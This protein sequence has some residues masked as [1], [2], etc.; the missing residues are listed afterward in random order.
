[1]SDSFL[2]K[3]LAENL[4]PFM[5]HRVTS[6]L[7]WSAEEKADGEALHAACSYLVTPDTPGAVKVFHAERYGGGG[8]QRNGGGARCG[9]DGRYQVK[10]IGANPLVGQG[11]DWYH[12]NGELRAEQ[13]IYEALWSEMLAQTLPYGAARTHAILLTDSYTHGD[14]TRTK[15]RSRRALL[16]REPLVR[17]AH[18]ERTPYFR[19]KAEYAGQLMHDVQRVKSVLRRL[20]DYLPVP[21][22]GFSEQAARDPRRRCLEG[23]YELTKRLARQMAFCRTRFLMLT[24][25]S[26]NITMDGRVLDFNGLTCLFP[27]DHRYDFEYQL[28]FAQLM[29]EPAIIQNSLSELCFYLGKYLF[30]RPFIAIAQQQVKTYFWHFFQQAC[31]RGYLTLLGI[32]IDLLSPAETPKPLERLANSFLQLLIHRCRKLY[33]SAEM[34][35][36]ESPLE[37]LV[38]TLIRCSQGH[39]VPTHDDF[40]RDARFMGTLR[41]FSQVNHWLVE[42]C[43]AQGIDAT[44]IQ[45][46][47]AQQARLRLRPRPQCGKIQMLNEIT[48]LVEANGDDDQRLRQLLTDMRIKAVAFAKETFGG[49]PLVIPSRRNEP[50]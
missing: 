11:S 30:D 29:R 48:A 49:Q 20:P 12:S 7:I 13:A 38:V 31:C 50:A 6:S 42:T 23:M 18:F 1:M 27:S 22:A 40:S 10:G 28:K 5:A 24:T 16:V 8:I 41:A 2:L 45:K 34:A 15:G 32:P 47:M 9:F 37:R 39:P 19:P 26:S 4:V 17:P 43:R 21:T 46:G 3:D 36:D 44:V 33:V 35:G 14:F 25:S